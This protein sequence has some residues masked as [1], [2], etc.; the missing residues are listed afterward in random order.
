MKKIFFKNLLSG[1]R[2][3]EALMD[4][5]GELI[6]SAKMVMV[7]MSLVGVRRLFSKEDLQEFLFRLYFAF[8]SND[9]M[10]NYFTDDV[11]LKFTYEGYK[12]SFTIEDIIDCLGI[13]V[14]KKVYNRP[15]E[16][17]FNE[18]KEL[19]NQIED[20]DFHF[21]EK[22]QD[23][24]FI[25]HAEIFSKSIL[26]EVKFDVWKDLELS[27]KPSK[28][29]INELLVKYEIDKYSD[30]RELFKPREELVTQLKMSGVKS[31]EDLHLILE[32][33]HLW[34]KG[35][36]QFNREAEKHFVMNI[37]EFD[38]S[39]YQKF[40]RGKNGFVDLDRIAEKFDFHHLMASDRSN[41][42]YR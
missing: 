12:H 32:L 18:Y 26:G 11:L 3:P 2:N 22:K 39:K 41:G 20:L 38:Y 15:R 30:K 28:D 4:T 9:L 34:Q 37:C 24:N 10:D 14:S 40:N 33:L 23:E 21:E 42:W 29:N 1:T 27:I 7:L 5:E 25:K 13:E 36:V 6:E 31:D 35:Y 16:V 8:K 19:E 17:Y